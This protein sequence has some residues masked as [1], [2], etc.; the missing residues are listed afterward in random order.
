MEHFLNIHFIFAWLYA[1]KN[2]LKKMKNYLKTLIVFGSI[3]TIIPSC[4]TKAQENIPERLIKIE[5][6]MGDMIVKLYNET[7]LH[8]DNMIK[9]IQDNFYDKQLFHRVIKDFMV[10]G[11]DPQSTGAANGMRL[12]NGGPGYTIP[13]EFNPELIH[14]KGA[15][16]AARQGDAVNPQKASSGSQ[17]YLVVGRVFTQDQINSFAQS[18][19]PFTEESLEAYTTMGGTPHLDGSYTVF[20]EIVLGLEIL[21]RIAATQTDTYDRPIEDVIYSISLVE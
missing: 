21:D 4:Q 13:A 18:G 19:A 20:G 7:P 1:I 11:G 9:L 15:L 10:Q 3:L 2:T 17:F 12:G 8:R 14:K 5:T 16:A 6:S